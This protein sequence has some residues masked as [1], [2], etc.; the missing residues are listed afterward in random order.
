[1]SASGP[2]PAALALAVL[3]L[4]NSEEPGNE[5]A[6]NPADENGGHSE[7]DAERGLTEPDPLASDDESVGEGVFAS[8]YRKVMTPAERAEYLDYPHILE[9][10]PA[11]DR[12]AAGEPL[13]RHAWVSVVAGTR[14]VRIRGF[15]KN[16]C[17]EEETLNPAYMAVVPSVVAVM[18]R[19]LWERGSPK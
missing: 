17:Y 18:L 7:L 1:M 8:V 16:T 19:R 5:D 10:A 9:P 6:P 13:T 14:R 4:A 12:A 2:A 3:G 15:W 11:V